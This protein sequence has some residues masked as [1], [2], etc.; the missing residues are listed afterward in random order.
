[1]TGPTEHPSAAETRPEVT[2]LGQAWRLALCLLIGLTAWS[3][4]AERE[5][6]EQRTMFWF[7][8]VLGALAFVLVV[9]RRRAPVAIAA[10]TACLSTFSG[11]AAGPATL[12]AVS[13]ATT[14]RPLPII[15]IG[16]LNIACALG[17]IFYAPVEQVMPLWVSVAITLAVNTAMMGWGMYI[18][19]RRELIWTLRQRAAR[20]EREQELRVAQGRSQERE[21]IA[22]EMHDV[23]AHRITQISMQAGALAFREDLPTHQLRE[24]L[25]EIQGKA[26]E[27]IDELRGVLGVL[28]DHTGKLVDGPQPTYSDV[29]GLVAEARANGVTVELVDRVDRSTAAIPDPV[30]RAV[31]RIIQE[32]LTN[33]V[34][35]APGAHVSIE[36]SGS[37]RE[38]IEVLISNPLG[39]SGGAPHGAGL[40][41]VGLVER[42]ELRG[43]TLVHG[44]EGSAFV[45]RASIPWAA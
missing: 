24:G 39:F 2:P 34:K 35:H 36:I 6:A 42:A 25:G 15:A 37:R 26:G 17:Y 43:G 11:L 18:G 40:G 4:A 10:A 14:R 30:G 38:G 21:R 8:V 27:A 19:S 5:W 33:S 28:R 22:R 12:G 44:R 7:E 9:F 3:Q 41:L 23:L 29:G 31:Y 32:G 16:L 1:M 20:A 13:V 45:V